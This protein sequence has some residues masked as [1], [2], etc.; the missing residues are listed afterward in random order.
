MSTFRPK[1]IKKAERQ[2][3]AGVDVEMKQNLENAKTIKL[4]F[5]EDVN[6]NSISNKAEEDS[7]MKS[8]AK[9]S[10]MQRKKIEKKRN[11][12]DWTKNTYKCE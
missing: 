6:I 10:F 4:D 7:E 8:V 5:E 1:F 12:L 11:A 3:R 2:A 9:G